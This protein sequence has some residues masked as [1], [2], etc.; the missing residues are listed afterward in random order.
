MTNPG[1]QRLRT[2]FGN[3]GGNSLAAGIST[4]SRL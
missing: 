1:Y 2:L 3:G 4:A